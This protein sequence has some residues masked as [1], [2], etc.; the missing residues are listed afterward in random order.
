MP[1]MGESITEGTITKWL[2]NVGDLVEKDEPIF[3]ISTDKVDAEIPAPVAGILAEIVFAE[4]ELVQVNAVVAVISDSVVP[5]LGKPKAEANPLPVETPRGT[6][7]HHAVEN[8]GS[9]TRLVQV[10]SSQ[11]ARR[12]ASDNDVSLADISAAGLGGRIMKEDVLR[13][14]RESG[15]KQ[16]ESPDQKDEIVALSRMRAIIAERMVE[17]VRTSPHVHT[18]YKID[19][20]RVVRTRERLM[21]DFERQEGTKLTYLPFVATATIAALLK[22]PIVNASLIGGAIHY[23]GHINLGIAISVDW[24]LIVPVIRFAERLSFRGLAHAI[25]DLA[26]RARSKKLNPEEVTGST[27]TISNVGVFGDYLTTSIIN[28]PDSAILC[29]SG[30]RKEPVV[31]TAADGMDTLAIRSMQCLTLGFDHRLIDGADACRFMLELKAVL[32]GWN[33]GVQ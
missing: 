13:Q 9:E 12:I 16:Q 27:F 15:N 7:I 19:M 6:P 25:N 2:K 33:L 22:H 1:Q 8:R 32:E 3:E 17:S 24:G 18:V 29:T 5:G 30:L 21:A 20:T 28:P 23:H 31:V 14:I 26:A 10:P 11:L 4:G